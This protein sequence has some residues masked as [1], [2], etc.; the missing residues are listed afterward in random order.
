MD[1]G[2]QL[3]QWVGGDFLRWSYRSIGQF[4]PYWYKMKDHPSE[5]NEKK[6][7][8]MGHTSWWKFVF[9]TLSASSDMASYSRSFKTHFPR[10][11]RWI[12]ICFAEF[13]SILWHSASC[14]S[15]LN[16]V[17]IGKDYYT[18]GIRSD[19]IAIYT[20][21]IA[22]ALRLFAL[23]PYLGVTWRTINEG[24]LRV[25]CV[26][27]TLNFGAKYVR[28]IVSWISFLIRAVSRSL[29]FSKRHAP[30]PT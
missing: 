24:V 26:N 23:P 7:A 19:K 14:T 29:P 9:F 21:I 2:L 16:D 4:S 13:S 10:S 12:W 22:A 5:N 17:R 30:L 18:G 15:V 11:V 25:F 6:K 28:N 1:L 27:C 20:R 8:R 3:S